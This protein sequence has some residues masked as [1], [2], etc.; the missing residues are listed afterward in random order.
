MSVSRQVALL[1]LV[2]M[3]AARP[4]RAQFQP[5]EALLSKVTDIGVYTQ[6]SPT[7]GQAPAVVPGHDWNGF[8]VELSYTIKTG[9]SPIA[10]TFVPGKAE[11]V[12]T[13]RVQTNGAAPVQTKSTY[14]KTPAKEDSVDTYYVEFAVAYSQTYLPVRHLAPPAPGLNDIEIGGGLREFPAASIYATYVN[15]L[16]REKRRTTGNPD[17]DCLLCFDPYGGVFGGL[18]NVALRAYVP[19]APTA[20]GLPVGTTMLKGES[21]TFEGGVL[22]GLSHD[23]MSALH[24]FGEVERTWRAIPA[25]DWSGS[26]SNFYPTN[27]PKGLDLTAW[28]L[29]VGV[30]A[31]VASGK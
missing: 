25:L 24:V 9:K 23:L 15:P 16:K 17:A 22:A 12:P 31:H 13:E 7:W 27:L 4:M 29:S 20:V 8:G 14:V 3:S 21:S 5:I 30:Q 2:V 19:T 10:G 1:S 26:P 18:T 6:F 11:F 28:S